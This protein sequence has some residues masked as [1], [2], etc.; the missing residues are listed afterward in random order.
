MWIRKGTDAIS[1]ATVVRIY[2]VEKSVWMKS[3]DGSETEFAF[4][5][6]EAAEK[7][8]KGIMNIILATGKLLDVRSDGTVVA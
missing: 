7:A 1:L 8:F 3:V 5:T 2:L 4:D 6:E